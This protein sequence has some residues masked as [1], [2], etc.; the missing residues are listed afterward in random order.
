M[1]AIDIRVKLTAIQDAR[2]QLKA[3][4]GD[5]VELKKHMESLGVAT[6]DQKLILQQLGKELNASRKEALGLA[7]STKPLSEHIKAGVLQA[8]LLGSAMA[9]VKEVFNS[10]KDV[11]KVK[12]IEELT[13]D[14]IEVQDQLIGTRDA[15]KLTNDEFARYQDLL[16]ATSFKTGIPVASL[17]KSM[18]DIQA[19][20]SDLAKRMAFESNGSGFM[21]VA[22]STAAARSENTAEGI[23]ARARIQKDLQFTPGEMER[24]LNIVRAG[25]QKGAATA[26]NLMLGMGGSISR[27]AGLRGYDLTQPQQR[28][29]A[30]REGQAVGQVIASG[31][32]VKSPEQAATLYENLVGHMGRT[33][34]RK[35]FKENLGI[36]TLDKSGHV[37]PIDQI[38][39]ELYVKE[40]A[41]KLKPTAIAEAMHDEQ[42]QQAFTHL[43][44]NR[45]EGATPGAALRSVRDVDPTTGRDLNDVAFRGIFGS[46][47]GQLELNQRQAEAKALEDLPD[48]TKIIL[49][50]AR[51]AQRVETHHA[52]ESRIFDVV[53]DVLPAKWGAAARAGVVGSLAS[54]E[55]ESPEQER[56]RVLREREERLSAFG[57]APGQGAAAPTVN[58]NVTVQQGMVAQVT[59]E[60]KT[61]KEKAKGGGAGRPPQAGRM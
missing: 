50:A 16:K 31:A 58:V 60:A 19:V 25:E 59:S 38:L 29:A 56:A 27:L 18:M 9:K 1:S 39:D 47:K 34:T 5:T 24:A 7:T 8:N 48:R 23:K 10:L 35:D 2:Q 22:E 45:P 52:G 55:F 40:K 33:K 54:S 20:D 61:S 3:L 57:N 13:K 11:G 41:G 51:A 53:A 37:R 44:R 30:L 36:D 43:F 4:G 17:N 46:T 32:G 6:R 12:T 14:A 42:F 21:A 15:M 28:E 49:D 26:E